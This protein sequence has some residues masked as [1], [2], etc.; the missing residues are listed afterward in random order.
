MC[1][2]GHRTCVTRSDSVTWSLVSAE[3]ALAWHE[4]MVNG[5]DPESVAYDKVAGG[6]DASTAYPSA[7]ASAIVFSRALAAWAAALAA[8]F[9]SFD[10]CFFAFP[11]SAEL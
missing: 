5:R 7:F 2:G 4:E 6:T 11:I 10:F 9:L 1:Q 3:S 8:A